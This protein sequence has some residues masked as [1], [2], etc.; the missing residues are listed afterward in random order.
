MLDLR[1]WIFCPK[2]QMFGSRDWFLAKETMTFQPYSLTVRPY[3]PAAGPTSRPGSGQP[4]AERS[5]GPG[6]GA[7]AW[8]SLL[9]TSL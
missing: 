1:N 3:S 6:R 4:L 2:A 7:A 9:E 8:G 5:G